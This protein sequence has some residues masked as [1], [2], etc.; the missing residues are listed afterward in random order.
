MRDT[1]GNSTPLLFQLDGTRRYMISSWDARPIARYPGVRDSPYLRE[2]KRK[3]VA[4]EPGEA[5]TIADI[6]GPGVISPFYFHFNVRVPRTLSRGLELR[7]FWEDEE[8]PSVCVPVGDFFG[9]PFCRYVQYDALAQSMLN[10]GYVSRFPM[11]FRRR[12]RLVVRNSGPHAAE[13][14][15]YSIGWQ[16]GVQLPE[17][18]LYFHAQWRRSNPTREGVPHE[19][20]SV[21]GRRGQYVGCHLFQQNLDPWLRRGPGGWMYPSGAGM[22]NMEGWDEV[23]VDGE[24]E[25]SRHDTGTEEYFHTGPYFTHGRSTGIF[26]GCTMRSYLTGRMAAYRFHLHD[27]IPFLRDFRMLWR[28]G[29]L[30]SIRADFTTTAFWYQEEPHQHHELP[31][32]GQRLPN[33]CVPHALRAIALFPMVLGTKAVCRWIAA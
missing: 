33:G 19:V 15:L 8:T 18:L 6:E 11:P 17:D 14:I 22:G 30:D 32:F 7:F 27:P 4:V 12:A 24:T 2:F 31:P 9:S 16:K 26:E 13:R 29:L 1:S 10:G 21:Q 23:Y 3:C 20:L 5:M 25:P 28:H